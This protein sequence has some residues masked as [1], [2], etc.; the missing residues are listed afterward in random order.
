[1]QTFLQRKGEGSYEAEEGRRRKEKQESRKE[2]RVREEREE[3]KAISQAS[4][5][6]GGLALFPLKHLHIM[7]CHSDIPF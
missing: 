5:P 3:K 4:F 6:G 2:E 1:M 7:G